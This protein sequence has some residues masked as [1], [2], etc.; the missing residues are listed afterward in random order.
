MSDKKC[1]YCGE[2][3]QEINFDIFTENYYCENPECVRKAQTD[4]KSY[5]KEREK[6]ISKDFAIT[7]IKSEED[8]ENMLYSLYGLLDRS[9][10]TKE[11]GAL[12]EPDFFKNNALY[13]ISSEIDPKYISIKMG[14][15]DKTKVN[16]TI[17]E[18]IPADILKEA[19]KKAKFID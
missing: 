11:L 6:K 3:S 4:T 9:G 2:A 18:K 19:M 17:K 12:S 16:I 5:F 13:L 10:K 1:S 15:K 14:D 8:F 7:D